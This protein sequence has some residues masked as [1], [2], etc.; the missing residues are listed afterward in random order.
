MIGHVDK[1][2]AHLVDQMRRSSSSIPLNIAEGSAKTGVREKAHPYRIAR[3]S[4]AESAA[5]LDLLHRLG[6]ISLDEY[7]S[8][9]TLA[10]RIVGALINLAKSVEER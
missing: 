10:R 8:G 1:R 6:H 2:G 9:K 7:S 3:G 5:C 4:A